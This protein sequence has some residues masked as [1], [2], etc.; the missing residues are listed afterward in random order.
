MSNTVSQD[1][2]LYSFDQKDIVG[3][4]EHCSLFLLMQ[5]VDIR[6]S[7]TIPKTFITQYLTWINFIFSSAQ[8][9]IFYFLVRIEEKLTYMIDHYTLLVRITIQFLTPL[10]VV[11]SGGT[12]SLKSTPNYRFLR[13]FSW[14]FYLLS[15]F[16]PEIC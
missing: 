16:L 11:C 10:N 6:K 8:E 15:E 14:K 9:S 4:F 3:G 2:K 7:N 5:E 12:Y 1:K 13:N